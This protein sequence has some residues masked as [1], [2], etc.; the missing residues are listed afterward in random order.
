MPVLKSAAVA[1]AAVLV[2]SAHGFAVRSKTAQNSAVTQPSQ[3][4]GRYEA[5]F[6][7]QEQ[8]VLVCLDGRDHV[9]SVSFH[10]LLVAHG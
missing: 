1:G 10:A 5:P 9:H 8:H 6:Y 2:G 4:V 7:C 3:H